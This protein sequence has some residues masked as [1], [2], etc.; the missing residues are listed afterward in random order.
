MS[1]NIQNAQNLEGDAIW[2]SSVQL[3]LIAFRQHYRDVWK[4]VLFV[5]LMLVICFKFIMKINYNNLNKLDCSHIT[6]SPIC[7]TSGSGCI[8]CITNSNCT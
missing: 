5:K 6:D 3:I 8:G 2:N 7:S 4:N 1:Q